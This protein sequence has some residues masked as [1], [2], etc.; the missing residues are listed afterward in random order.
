MRLFVSSQ[1]FGGQGNKQIGFLVVEPAV[2]RSHQS[3]SRPGEQPF[4]IGFGV[5][6]L[7]NSSRTRRPFVM[8]DSRAQQFAQYVTVL[9]RD[10]MGPEDVG[11]RQ[12]GFDLA[13]PIPRSVLH[14][15]V[16]ATI[17]SDLVTEKRNQRR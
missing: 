3:E 4:T 13:P 7:H 16:A 5:R 15:I 9:T 2:D 6:S 1:H 10:G 11:P 17:R 14:T 12:R 8:I